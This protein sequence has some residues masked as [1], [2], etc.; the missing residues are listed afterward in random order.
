MPTD[1]STSSYATTNF[2]T[3]YEFSSA[4]TVDKIIVIGP[5]NYATSEGLQP[6]NITDV[7]AL[8]YD[9]SSLQ[10]S[11]NASGYVRSPI[12]ATPDFA[13]TAGYTSVRGRLHNLSVQVEC[14][15]TS[16]GLVPPGS[17]YIGTVPF[18]E[19]TNFAG[20]GTKT[21]K[22]TWAEDSIAV[23]Y[24]KSHSAAGL[25]SKPVRIHANIAEN[26]AFKLW[27]DF[28]IPTTGT[29]L[30]TLR[31]SNSLEPIVIYVPRV[32]AGATPTI[33]QYR[34]N[35]GHQWCTRHPNDPAMRATQILHKPSSSDLWNEASSLLRTAGGSFASAAAAPFGSA[36]GRRLLGEYGGAAALA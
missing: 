8:E 13:A 25:V 19:G 1:E 14:L 17:I 36:V 22:E 3:P 15:G 5:R 16:A 21:L 18:I 31:I 24:L 26:V 34:V 11:T 6:S 30:A 32:G 10:S 9:A 23:G 7:I 12:L 33:V 2:V 28:T 27:H 35:I 29:N 4:A 20:L